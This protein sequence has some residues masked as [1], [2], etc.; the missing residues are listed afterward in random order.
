MTSVNVAET[1]WTDPVEQVAPAAPWLVEDAGRQLLA[2]SA[3]AVPWRYGQDR[4]P[5]LAIVKRRRQGD[6]GFPK[7]SPRPGEDLAEAAE[8]ELLEETGLAGGHSAPLANLVYC[9]RS[10]RGKLASYWLVR[11][12]S[13]EFRPNREVAR[14]LWLPPAQARVALTHQRERVVL[15]LAVEALGL[16]LLAG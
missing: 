2:L 5:E 11:A 7:G 10:G 14:L 9:S 15:D 8:R 12:A 16:S 13:G 3:A 6:W 4:G 1:G